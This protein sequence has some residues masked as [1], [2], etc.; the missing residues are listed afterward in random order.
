MK[1]TA[2]KKAADTCLGLEP[3][4]K[5]FPRENPDTKTRQNQEIWPVGE[6]E[7]AF[8]CG[9]SFIWECA[10]RGDDQVRAPTDT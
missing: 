2:R 5:F 4:A 6:Q 10:L 8:S 7:R 9:M 1:L 3:V